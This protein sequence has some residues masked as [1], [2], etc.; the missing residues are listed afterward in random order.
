MNQIIEFL[1][2]L[3]QLEQKAVHAQHKK[4]LFDEYNELA[5][6]IK[7]NMY[8]ITVGLNLPVETNP[9]SDSYYEAYINEPYPNKR[10]IYKISQYNNEKYESIWV[11]YVSEVNPFKDGTIS[12]CLVV[13]N[14]DGELK[15]LSKFNPDYDTNEWSFRGGDR[16]FKNYRFGK[17]VVIERL[18]SPLLSESWSIQEY[19]KDR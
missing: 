9:E 19:N 13:G 16:D 15:I 14:I 10:L 8:N 4:D 5:T 3:F 17:P 2:S 7:S 1:E 18:T 11:C 12:S 6:K